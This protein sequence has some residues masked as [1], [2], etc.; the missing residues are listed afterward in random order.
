MTKTKS[1]IMMTL[2]TLFL[3]PA[4]ASAQESLHIAPYFDGRFNKS[5]QV[6]TLLAK[7]KPL[8]SYNLT[9]Y[10]S[11]TFESTMPV[12]QKIEEAVLAD[13][14]QAIDKETGYIDGRLLYGFYCLKPVKGQKQPLRYIFWRRT[15]EKCIL[16]YME[17][18]ASL[19]SIKKM[20]Q[21]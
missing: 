1:I 18:S 9:L 14:K 11:M 19:D 13:G 20:F 17:G 21:K 16:V 10:R 2:M 4:L 15:D 5:R 12:T 7:G 3:L 8:K 6:V